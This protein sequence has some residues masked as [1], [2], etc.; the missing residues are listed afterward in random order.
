[1][2]LHCGKTTAYDFYTTLEKL[3]NN[4]GGRQYTYKGI[5]YKSW[6]LSFLCLARHWRHLKELKRAGRG[7]DGIRKVAET[8]PGELAVKFIACPSPGVNL[9]EGWEN[10]SPD[11]RFLYCIFIA[12]DACFP[13]KRRHAGSWST[14]PP[15]C[16]GGS[17]FVE[18]GLY[19][20]YCKKMQDQDEIC[21]CTRLA[22]MDFANT[23]YS[24]GCS[25]TGVG[26]ATCGCHE[27]VMPNGVG[28]LQKGE[29]YGNIDYIWASTMRHVHILLW[30]LLTYNII[31]QWFKKLAECIKNLLP[32]LHILGHLLSCQDY[33]NLLYTLG[34]AMSDME[35]IECIWSGSGLLGTS[36]CEM[37]PGNRQNTIEDYWHNWNWR[38]NVLQGAILCKQL[39]RALKE[40]SDQEDSFNTFQA[41]QPQEVEAWKK[42]VENFEHGQS[43]E[44]PFS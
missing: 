1:M 6:Y 44:N 23:K 11:D 38:K 34:A 18:S 14:D 5:W 24:K 12:I 29:Q 33:F 25:T 28:D 41:N 31:C 7:N 21:T 8:Q 36:T 42:L 43:T 37:G 40:L 9:P 35:G 4:L 26:M 20:E 22:A 15:M 13:L 30:I 2:L 19:R 32:L 17:Y 16:D 10:A 39:D 3:T 27:I